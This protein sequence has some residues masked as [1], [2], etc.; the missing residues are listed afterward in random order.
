MTQSNSNLVQK[1]NVV[2][3][4]SLWVLDTKL[5]ENIK[6]HYST[7]M[8]KLPVLCHLKL[9]PGLDWDWK[10]PGTLKRRPAQDRVLLYYIYIYILHYAVDVWPA[11]RE[12]SQLS[13]WP[14]RLWLQPKAFISTPVKC[15]FP[16]KISC[17]SQQCANKGGSYSVYKFC[18]NDSYI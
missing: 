12:I 1:S 17:K 11:V 2:L 8:D 7:S 6:L 9:Q 15:I 14:V 18:S 4:P 10:R 13:R 5:N 3:C 16:C